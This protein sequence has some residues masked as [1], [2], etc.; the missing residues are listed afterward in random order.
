[1]RTLQFH[2]FYSYNCDLFI[3]SLHRYFQFVCTVGIPF[4]L[5]WECCCERIYF[6]VVSKFVGRPA[7][8]RGDN[9]CMCVQ[10]GEWFRQK[11]IEKDRFHCYLFIEIDFFFTSSSRYNP[12][13]VWQFWRNATPKPVRMSFRLFF[14][15]ATRSSS[16]WTL[17]S[18]TRFQNHLATYQVQWC[19]FTCR[20]ISPK[21]LPMSGGTL[22]QCN[23]CNAFVLGSVD[24]YC[25]YCTTII[26]V[27]VT[28]KDRNTRTKKNNNEQRRVDKK[29]ER[30]K[31]LKKDHFKCLLQWINN[32]VVLISLW[33][34]MRSFS[35]IKCHTNYNVTL[36]SFCLC[37]SST[38]H[39]VCVCVCNSCRK[40]SR[41]T[42]LAI[43][44][45]L[46]RAK[47]QHFD[48]QF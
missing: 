29:K 16:L 35:F 7:S 19:R 48:T 45:T 6:S 38:L 9:G 20:L 31:W 32:G 11:E 8:R 42:R 39:A 43:R 25:Y 2:R 18:F 22:K 10:H 46:V 34:V 21:S 44:S 4:V 27:V 33:N 37:A 17:Y 14:C 1:M 15:L 47:H 23:F 12:N 36:S 40:C 28:S 41:H 26:S 5:H 24:H 30:L 3:I 13:I